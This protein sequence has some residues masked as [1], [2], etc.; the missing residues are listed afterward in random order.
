[1]RRVASLLLLSA[2]VVVGGTPF[3]TSA[4]TQENTA[5]KAQPNLD[6]KMSTRLREEA[7]K[8]VEG[9]GWVF[10]GA[11]VHRVNNYCAGTAVAVA[12]VGEQNARPVLIQGPYKFLGE[13]KHFLPI[14]LKAGRYDLRMVRCQNIVGSL[15]GGVVFNGPYARFEVRAGELVD[16]GTLRLE[17]TSENFLL[18]QGRIRLS[19]EATNPERIAETRKQTPATMAKLVKRHMVV[20]GPAERKTKGPNLF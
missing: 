17:Y 5:T 11:T 20:A 8:G 1:M 9:T 18:G 10:I 19:V 7:A 14:G 12:R 4:R 2:S 15:S 13:P 6:Q 3:V 16:L